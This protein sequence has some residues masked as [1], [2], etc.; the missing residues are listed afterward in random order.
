M[1]NLIGV[2]VLLMALQANAQDFN[3]VKTSVLINQY[4]AS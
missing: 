4:D 2:L 1:K 3:K